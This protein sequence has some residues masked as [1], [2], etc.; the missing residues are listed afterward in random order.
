MDHIVASHSNITSGDRYAEIV[1]SGDWSG[2]ADTAAVTISGLYMSPTNY[3]HIYTDAA[4]RASASW[5]TSKYRLETANARAIGLGSTTSGN[6]LVRID[7]LQIGLSSA[8]GN[9]QSIF[10]ND[11]AAAGDTWWVSNCLLK[12]CANNSY[13]IPVVWAEDSDATWY[14]W[15][16]VCYGVGTT[17]HANNSCYAAYAGTHNI[18]SCV[19]IGGVYGVWFNGSGKVCTVKNTYCGGTITEDF[20]RA[21]GVLAKTNCAS[22]DQSA[23]DTSGTD[24]TATNCVAAA[25][26]LSTSTFVNVTAGSE[27]FHLVVGSALIGA[28]ATTSGDSAPMDFTTDIDGDARA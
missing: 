1:I 9:Y 25:V 24:E 10:Y 13:R 2:G 4:N 5:D 3:L 22:E 21:A 20:Y 27:D 8:S 28:G 26:A 19:L 14:F 11:G 12:Q 17:N 7:G 23:D 18:Y 16:N 6:G 15:N